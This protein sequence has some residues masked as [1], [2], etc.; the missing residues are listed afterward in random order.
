MAETCDVCGKRLDGLFISAA[1]SPRAL[2]QLA[3]A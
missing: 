1:Q 3:S 2:S